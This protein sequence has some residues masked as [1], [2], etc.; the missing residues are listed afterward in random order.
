MILD[1]LVPAE[2]RRQ[3][4]R[5]LA[6]DARWLFAVYEHSDFTRHQGKDDCEQGNDKYPLHIALHEAASLVTDAS[7]M[8]SSSAWLGRLYCLDYFLNVLVFVRARTSASTNGPWRQ[9][10][11]P[12]VLLHNSFSSPQGK[13]KP[14]V[15]R[16][17][18][19]YHRAFVGDDDVKAKKWQPSVWTRKFLSQH[20]PWLPDR[21]WLRRKIRV[22]RLLQYY[23]PPH[24]CPSPEHGHEHCNVMH[25][26]FH[27]QLHSSVAR[28]V[29][30]V[31]QLTLK[32]GKHSAIWR[33]A[34]WSFVAMRRGE[35]FPLRLPAGLNC[36]LW[37]DRWAFAFA[38]LVP[39][40]VRRCFYVTEAA[41]TRQ[42]LWYIRQDDWH[43]MT[44]QCR[45]QLC[46]DLLEPMG[47]NSD[48]SRDR[49]R[50]QEHLPKE[51]FARLRLMPKSA[52]SFRPIMNMRSA[53]KDGGEKAQALREA[54]AV[55]T[56]LRRRYPRLQGHSVLGFDEVVHRLDCFRASTM[57]IID[58]TSGVD[59]ASR[60]DQTSRVDHEINS[61]HSRGSDY[62]HVA[63]FDVKACYDS[64]PQDRLMAVVRDLLSLHDAY[65][66]RKVDAVSI[67]NGQP[68]RRTLIMAHVSDD[69][70]PHPSCMNGIRSVLVHDRG[71]YKTVTSQHLLSSIERHVCRPVVRFDGRCWLQRHG[72]P[73]GSILS[74]TLCALYYGHLDRRLYRSSLRDPRLLVLRFV[75]DVLVCSRHGSLVCEYVGSQGR[76]DYGFQVHPD[77]TLILSDNLDADGGRFMQWCGLWIDRT[78]LSVWCRPVG[79]DA[80]ELRD[81]LSID[82][83]ARPM[84][85]LSK[86]LASQARFRLQPIFLNAQYPWRCLRNT[87]QSV[88]FD[89]EQRAHIVA[90]ELRRRAGYV[91]RSD[92]VERVLGAFRGQVLRTAKRRLPSYHTHLDRIANCFSLN[93]HAE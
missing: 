69:A 27:S 10:V 56:F 73:Q 81:A 28:F 32:I 84:E 77:K 17:G 82:Y 8:L 21:R 16:H 47:S 33:R 71:A 12:A 72:L 34:V 49:P 39:H 57:N 38:V 6:M 85:A 30:R 26:P 70:D 66:L 78:D 76:A 51:A 22:G 31:L 60:V 14:V 7:L 36:Q 9:V 48:S 20:A 90:R 18:M 37:S 42:R 13:K 15:E 59:Q 83:A 43:S 93:R 89:A 64:I 63:K 87:L 58:Q 35:R 54:L 23:C 4:A 92:V 75:D 52:A 55:L 68:W 1:V 79:E 50:K 74:S 53:S 11:G 86:Q 62:Y 88:I 19:L 2:Y 24:I 46:T 45:Q 67:V 40:V 29:F 44:R 91:L 25:R 3:S 41:A 65:V 61:E 80:S 5:V